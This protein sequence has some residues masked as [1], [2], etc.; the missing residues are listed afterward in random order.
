MSSFDN[1]TYFLVTERYRLAERAFRAVTKAFSDSYEAWANLG[2]ALLMQYADALEPEDLKRLGIGQIV[3]GGFYRRP[4]TLE[5]KVRGI[6][7]ELWWDAVGALREAERRARDIAVGSDR[8]EQP[9]LVFVTANLGL[10]Y[11]L[12]PFGK[13]PGKAIQ[14]FERAETELARLKTIN[15]F[16]QLG[17]LNN[18]AVAYCAGDR[19]EECA[20]RLVEARE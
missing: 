12:R 20:S 19:A 5:A 10:A 4:A 3:V 14:Y 11:L 1:G 13:D 2:Y 9:N 18:L 15:P 8:E 17:M 6:D 16:A 7:E